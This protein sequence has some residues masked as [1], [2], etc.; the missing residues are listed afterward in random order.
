MAKSKKLELD[1]FGIDDDL[2]F[3][4]DFEPEKTKDDRNPKAK[5]GKLGKAAAGGAKDAVMSPSFLRKMMKESLPRGY[6]STLDL[7]D[8]S[9]D[10]LKNA[11]HSAAREIKP[12]LNDIKRTTQRAMPS[13]SKALPKSVADRIAKWSQTDEQ[14]AQAG[15]DSQREDALQMMLG[16]VFK[17]N[18]TKDAKD[19]QEDEIKDR[20]K[21]SISQTR[22]RDQLTQL[23]AIRTHLSSMSSY[24]QKIDSSFMRKSLE[25]Q[26]RSYYVAVDMLEETKRQNALSTSALEAIMKNTALPDFAKLK[27]SERMQDIL[28]NNFLGAIGEGI[29][30]KRR[31]FIKNLSKRVADIAKDRAVGF[32]QSVRGASDA[33][34]MAMDANEMMSGMGDFGPSKGEMGASLGGGL[35][36]EAGGGWLARKLGRAAAKNKGIVKRGNALQQITENVPQIVGRWARS[37]K[38]ETGIGFID[39]LLNFSK[40]VV[41]SESMIPSTKMNIDGINNLQDQSLFTRQANKSI[42]E[43]IPGYLARIFRELQVM[44]TGNDKIG[45]T[46][47]DYKANKFSSTQEAYKSA[48][49]SVVGGWG[50]EGTKSQIDSLLDSVDPKKTLSPEERAKLGQQLLKD[51]LNNQYGDKNYFTDAR[52][53]GEKTAGLFK[54]FLGTDDFGGKEA[55]LNRRYRNLGSSLVDS[56][57]T[58]Q[59]LANAGM[60]DM[61]MESGIVSESGS[62]DLDRL[63]ELNY[64]GSYTPGVGAGV[65]PGK[66][67]LPRGQRAPAPRARRARP[68]A[69]RVEQ[70]ASSNMQSKDK[71]ELLAAIREGNATSFAQSAAE[72][73]MRIEARLA[74]GLPTYQQEGPAPQQEQR[75]WNTSI[76]NAMGKIGGL[77]RK[78]FGFVKSGVDTAVGRAT[79]LAGFALQ[80]GKNVLGAAT[81]RFRQMRDV[82]LPGEDLPRLSA[83]KMRMGLYRDQATGKIIKTYKDI[84]GTVVEVAKD[85]TQTVVLEYN[86]LKDAFVKDGMGQKLISGLGAV[87]NTVRGIGD[88]AF[89]MAGNLV[90]TGWKIAKGAWNLALNR[91]QDVYA[92]RDLK[93]PALSA[94]IM[95]T[96]GYFSKR[97]GKPINHPG[98]IDGAVFTM[99]DG[100]EEIVLT[101][102][103]IKQGLFDGKGN[104]IHTGVAKLIKKGLNFAGAIAGGAMR[105]A[106][107]VKDTV[108]GGFNS[109]WDWFAKF[110]LPDGIAFSGSKSIVQRLTEIRDLLVERLPE[111]KKVFG[112][113][114]GDGVREGSYEDIMAKRREQSE[115]GQQAKQ[116]T[117]EQKRQGGLGA[118][119]SGLFGRKKQDGEEEAKEG[120]TNVYGGGVSGGEG[121]GGKGGAKKPVPKG[122]WGKAGHY[123]KAGLGKA[124]GAVKG[125]GGIGLSLLGLGG[126]GLGSIAGGIGA[127]A[128]A[129]G[130]GAMAVG[131]ALATGIGAIGGVLL[132]VLSAPVVLG[133]LAVAAVGAA[134]YYGYKYLTRKT[135]GQVSKY[136]YAQYGFPETD[137]DH[138]NT[139]FGLEDKVEA[140]I[141]WKD[142]KPDLDAK[143][144]DMKSLVE[145]FGVDRKNLRQVQTWSKWFAD[146]FKPVYLTHIAALRAV[147]PQAKLG[148]VD[149]LK[150]EAMKRYFDLALFSDGPYDVASSPFPSQAFLPMDSSRVRA[151]GEAVKA[152]LEK[153]PTKQTDKPG[154]GIAA[155]A[156]GAAVGAAAAVNASNNSPGGDSKASPVGRTDLGKQD[157]PAALAGGGAAFTASF[158]G[159][160]GSDG[161]VDALSAIRYK[162]YGLSEL[163]TEKVRALQLLEQHVEKKV[164]YT[165]KGLASW[166]GQITTAVQAV[167]GAF[168][169]TGSANKDAYAWQSWF[170]LR[171]LPTYLN[172]LTAL[173]QAGG[174]M[175]ALMSP[176]LTPTASMDVATAI[177][178][179]KDENDKNVWDCAISPWPGYTLNADSKSIEPN[180]QALREQAKKTTMQE[181]TG[182]KESKG[183]GTDNG[184]GITDGSNK[185]GFM[186]RAWDATK[187]YASRAAS[188]V[189]SA[190]SSAWTGT[191][192]AASS[193]YNA[194]GT[195][196]SN[197]AGAVAS[198]A[199][200]AGAAAMAA[201]GTA[202][203][204]VKDGVGGLLSQ[205]PMPKGDGTYAAMKELI[206]KAS[207]MVG[208]DPKL[209]ATMAAIESGFR[210]T[211]KAGTSSATGLYQFISGTWKTMVKKYGAKYG[212]DATTS[213]TD[214]R[215]N[216][217]MGA[218]FIKENAKALSGVKQNL[219]DTDLY[220]AHFLGAGGARTFLKADPNAIA[221][222]VMPAA[223]TANRS[224][225]YDRDGTPRS[226]SAVY[227][228]INRRVR[229][230]GK[231]FGLDSGNAAVAQGAGGGRGSINPASATPDTTGSVGIGGEGAGGGRG[232]INPALPSTPTIPVSNTA[233]GGTD[234][235]AV[236]ATGASAAPAAATGGDQMAAPIP[237][238]GGGFQ[239][240]PQPPQSQSLMAQKQVQQDAMVQV[241]GSIDST[242]QKAAGIAAEQLVVLRLIADI[243]QRN[244]GTPQTSSASPANESNPRNQP[245]RT[246]DMTNAPVSM[247]KSA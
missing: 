16:D 3:S 178:S 61:L 21:E 2:D 71:D 62:I 33:A 39:N 72:T 35:A 63:Y 205:L 77:G 119:L 201:G 227:S 8:Q 45:L 150:P 157:N 233:P 246:S 106:K 208:V 142:G 27:N 121:K 209:M 193:A 49:D 48:F 228:E 82:Y 197:A 235:S 144:I 216:A 40:D 73:L 11:Y 244:G 133:A 9:I 46:V 245:R 79:G 163:V 43:I 196:L 210:A 130:S 96:G 221:A 154:T 102:D 64:G 182:N 190:A 66:G 87:L 165:G 195:G 104:I 223:A 232:A 24:Q 29:F 189:S 12:A 118:I 32:A 160:G 135:I 218:E 187:D 56:R 70:Q 202:M 214:P 111:N 146:R 170:R 236:P 38:G 231:Q 51:N 1:D 241:L 34:N 199:S 5:L 105:A 103:D 149:S 115:A 198:G 161:Q 167:G 176:V 183:T 117:E 18:A 220:L 224:I 175:V 22:H 247:A 109:A 152:E 164:T 124:W 30:D 75:W 237:N 113:N 173:K 212:I 128:G 42:T 138:L 76:G 217:L 206:D 166:S 112:D 158:Q 7:A 203:Q 185:P 184:T 54:D 10:S 69:G 94:I 131:G 83:W 143:K 101:D 89:G 98:D 85:G 4:F 171:F 80:T 188:A 91:A 181:Q 59:N 211:V 139:V 67:G 230:K 215:A 95:R 41:N 14:R 114:N 156:A 93:S 151:V 225:F 134:G 177:Y 15:R 180:L 53:H 234:T 172:Y 47:Y 239:P 110:S 147:D 23:D 55:G 168:G 60:L 186:S 100:K 37:N 123:G 242:G 65:D 86:R 28:R 88:Q 44:R 207:E 129:I 132:S 50:K 6:G 148:D 125:L 179:S 92:A 25:L 192:S 107:W 68:A 240:I 58:I 169:V 174:R 213:P 191:K 74:M 81:A 238:G 120:D 84:S 204:A 108:K 52:T 226:F 219:T 78:A 19:R 243:L 26:F 137:K 13:I 159:F 229:S 162:T 145:E 20:L 97:T 127:T 116:S 140:G 90:G 31:D 122:F 136:R 155:T 141:V 126:V 222:N 57:E 194:V 153:M 200:A 99:K 36:A 17:F